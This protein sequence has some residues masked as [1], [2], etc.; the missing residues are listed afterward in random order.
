MKKSGFT[1]IEL[2]F[3]IVI[4]G[5]LAAVAIPKLAATRTDAKL[6]KAAS[7]AATALSDLGAYYTAHGKFETDVTKMTNVKFSDNDLTDG[8]DLLVDGKKCLNF[9]VADADGNVTIN[10]DDA[11]DK[12]DALCKNFVKIQG[13]KDINKTHLF[14]GSS[15]SY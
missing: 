7:E 9:K 1:M 11:A 5:I 3:V 10:S 12:T 6:A 15:V 2:I 8:A 13:I 4:L 14:G